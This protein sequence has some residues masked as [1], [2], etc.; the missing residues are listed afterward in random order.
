MWEKEKL[1]V[2]SNFSFSHSV[3]KRLVS[4]GHKKVSLCGNGLN[5]ITYKL[6]YI[7]PFHFNPF[8]L[9]SFGSSNSAAN[10]DMMSKILTN[11][12]II[13]WLSRKHCGKRRNCSLVQ[14]LLYPLFFQKLSVVDALK[15]VSKELRV[16]LSS[17]YSNWNEDKSASLSSSHGIIY[18][19][20]NHNQIFLSHWLKEIPTCWR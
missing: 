11:R 13:F 1:L 15:W 10:K 8:P 2:T 20:Q 6:N 12:D 19:E 3:F 5:L 7:I 18:I 17:Q 16:K 14:F 4:Q 9:P